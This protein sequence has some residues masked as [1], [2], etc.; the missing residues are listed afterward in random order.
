MV[1]SGHNA[2]THANGRDERVRF[3]KFNLEHCEMYWS[4]AA[5]KS[6]D[7]TAVFL[8]DCRDVE[9]GLLSRHLVG[10]ER[11]ASVLLSCHERGVI[12]TLHASVPMDTAM[13]FLRD[14]APNFVDALSRCPKDCFPIIVIG[15]GGKSLAY[16]ERPGVSTEPSFT[17]EH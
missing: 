3:L 15:S 5:T 13:K 14:T 8:I 7:D 1:M 16:R 2:H 6:D 4:M 11:H 12:P 10:E 9:G 17:I